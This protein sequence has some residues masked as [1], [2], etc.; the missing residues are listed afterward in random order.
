MTLTSTPRRELAR[1]RPRRA[2]ECGPTLP[3]W[4]GVATG[5][6]ASL[7]KNDSNDSKITI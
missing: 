7:T 4:A 5:D 2:E 6:T 3:P 1:P